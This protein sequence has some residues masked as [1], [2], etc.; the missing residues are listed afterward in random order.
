MEKAKKPKT[1]LMGFIFADG[2]GYQMVVLAS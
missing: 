2:C 1:V